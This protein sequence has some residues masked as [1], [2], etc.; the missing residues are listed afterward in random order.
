MILS[1]KERKINPPRKFNVVM[2]D[3]SKKIIHASHGMN[4]QLTTKFTTLNHWTLETMLKS[5]LRPS[6][7]T[8]LKLLGLSMER[9]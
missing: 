1:K 7:M 4:L 9:K 2:K 3:I 8:R 6:A 5:K